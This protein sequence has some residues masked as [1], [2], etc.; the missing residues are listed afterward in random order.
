[1]E[2]QLSQSLAVIVLGA[3]LIGGPWWLISN[4]VGRH[5]AK[6]AGLERIA[7]AEQLG[8]QLRLEIGPLYDAEITKLYVTIS[9][10][11]ASLGFFNKPLLLAAIAD[12]RHETAA[13]EQAKATEPAAEEAPTG[14]HTTEAPAE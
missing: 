9:N 11:I 7:N 14:K 8:Y 2:H 10:T 6:K 1:M 5:K 13:A 12:I 4:A 3:I